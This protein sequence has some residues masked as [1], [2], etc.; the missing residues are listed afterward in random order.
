VTP[1]LRLFMLTAHILSSVGLLGAIAAFLALSITGLTSQDALTVRGVYLA[2]DLIARL[3]I[4]PLAFAALLT[5]VVQ[6]LGTPWGLFRHYWVLLKLLLTVFATTVLLLKMELIRYVANRA[7]STT[8][9]SADLHDA[10]LQ[11]VVHA[12]G[13][14]L[15]LLVPVVL[16]V[17]KPRGMTRY[18]ARKLREQRVLSQSHVRVRLGL[19][20]PKRTLAPI[21]GQGS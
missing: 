2:M 6:S 9:S 13:G 4:V 12:A 8:L 1:S 19:S 15:V 10:R 21:N 3:V 14:L 16:S 17:Y 5:G 18:G 20:R 11:L 7:A